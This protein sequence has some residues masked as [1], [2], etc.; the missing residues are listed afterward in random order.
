MPSKS[1]T[2]C[3]K[4]KTGIPEIMPNYNWSLVT[5]INHCGNRC[6]GI[7]FRALLFFSNTTTY[8]LITIKSIGLHCVLPNQ[9]IT[10]HHTHRFLLCSK[11]TTANALV[12]EY[13]RRK[14][15]KKHPSHP[16]NQHLRRE[17]P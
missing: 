9:T 15:D 3:L 11:G 14:A 7:Q 12:T 4:Y 5:N 16:S 2:A 10:M 6:F 17:I 1:V 13:M 8:R